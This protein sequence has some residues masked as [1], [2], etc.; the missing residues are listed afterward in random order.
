MRVIIASDFHLKFHENEEDLQRR[1]R[2][3]NFL[4]S[5]VGKT[6]LL[7][8]NGDVFDLWFTWKNVIIKGYFPILKKLADIKENGC[9]IVFISGN[10]DFWFRDF[11]TNF[12]DIEVYKN[13]F[14]E[15]IDGKN[16]LVSHGDL[17]T[18]NDWRYKLFR[19]LVRNRIVMKIFEMLHPDLALG[20]GKMMSRSSRKKRISNNLTIEREKGL[21]EFA[22]KQLKNFDVVILGH[23]HLPK[24]ADFKNGIYANAGDWIINN[25][26]LEMIN[27]EIQLK[28]YK[29]ET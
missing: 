4:D 17:Y 6:D 10:H 9:R 15:E 7:I 20:I 1:E 8:L 26:Y 23:S 3:L 18:S 14:I 22:N 21:I 11:L 24:I 27:G 25:T 16:I 12:L 2:V 13:S 5:L 29:N 28:K 19:G